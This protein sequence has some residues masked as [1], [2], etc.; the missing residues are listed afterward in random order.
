MDSGEKNRADKLMKAMPD[1]LHVFPLVE[2][3]ITKENAH[4]ML[5]ESGIVRPQMYELGYGNNNC[6]GCVKGGMG[7]WNKIRRDFPATFTARARMERL[8][9]ATCIN[10]VYLDDLDP[11]RGRQESPIVGECGIFCEIL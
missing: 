3:G 7:Y 10:G 2:I 9:G 8:I 6:V 11:D 5:A 4:A 1:N